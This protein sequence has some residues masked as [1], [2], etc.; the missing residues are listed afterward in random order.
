[1]WC[2]RAQDMAGKTAA[3]LTTQAT[4]RGAKCAEAKQF[5]AII[6]EYI[7]VRRSRAVL[8]APALCAVC[9]HA[10]CVHAC[11]QKYNNK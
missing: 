5:Q 7:K 2:A 10:T 11:S 8:A 9:A 1:M 6:A 4:A 3:A